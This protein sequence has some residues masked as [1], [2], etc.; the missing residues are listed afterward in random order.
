[1]DKALPL[2]EETLTRRQDKLGPDHPDTLHSMNNLAAAYKI[3]GKLHKALPLLEEALA[4]R[5]VRLGPDHSDTLDSMNNLAATYWS[6]GK[7]DHSIPLFEKALLLY[8]AKL[9]P[10]H[11]LT[12]RTQV[13]LG[14]NYRDAKR[15]GEAIPLLEEALQR[16][17]KSSS[18]MPAQ[19]AAFLPSTLAETYDRAGQFAK[20]E[21]LYR[22]FLKQAEKQFGAK[23]PQTLGLQAQLGLNLLQQKKY[24]DAETLLRD[25]LKG[26]EKTQPD[27]WTTFNSQSL[28]GAAL[29]GQKKYADAEPLLL[30]GYQGMKKREKTIPQQGKVRLIEA[31]ERL[32]QLYDATGQKEAAARWRKEFQ[33]WKAA[34]KKPPP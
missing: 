13:N 10:D 33:T 11:P 5:K 22:G 17:Q 1:L 7:L 4:K 25:C 28:L 26:R 19:L 21:P 32:V 31:G 27:A 18:S 20:A 29:L 3:A 2:F 12:L 24:A 15:L 8:K 16:L 14:V 30:A 23:A 34:G 9:G 6:A